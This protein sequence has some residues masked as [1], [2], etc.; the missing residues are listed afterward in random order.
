M[1][2][3]LVVDDDPF[4]VE[5]VSILLELN[6]FTP[7]TAT[8]PVTAL[9]MLQ[10]E[11]FPLVLTD[12]RMRSENDGMEIVEAVRR[13]SPRTRVAAMSGYVTAATERRLLEAGARLVLRKPFEERELVEVLTSMLA[14]VESARS[15]DLDEVYRSTIGSLRGIVRGRFRFDAEDA[16]E[17][18]QEA[19]CLFLE[20]R[21]DVEKPRAWLSGTIANLCRQEI[22]RRVRSRRDEDEI[23]E[24]PVFS[25][26]EDVLALRAALQKLDPRS[27]VLCEMIGIEQRTYDEV[28]AAAEIP[29]G[30]VGPLYM[31]A[32]EKLR[33]QLG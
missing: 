15:E 3:I 30:S 18:I 5:S 2:K 19:W 16:E 4:V 27:R 6:N 1:R 29:L 33:K 22:D 23:P 17:L 24:L 13:L 20:K 8:D 14:E 26:S 11:F 31:R 21:R 9:A 7:K 12:L 25:A 28:S 32:K 10:E